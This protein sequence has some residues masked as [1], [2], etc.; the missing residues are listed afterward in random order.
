MFAVVRAAG[1]KSW[2]RCLLAGLIGFAS[3]QSM[4]AEQ[5]SAA[6]HVTVMVVPTCTV[7]AV[8]ARPPLVACGGRTGPTV[9]YSVPTPEG[10]EILSAPAGRSLMQSGS[11]GPDAGDRVGRAVLQVEF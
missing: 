3:V 9:R 11:A 6:L 10:A 1:R 7:T 8:A 2:T 4:I 5:A